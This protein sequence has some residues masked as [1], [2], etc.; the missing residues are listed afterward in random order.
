MKIFIGGLLVG[1]LITW[2]SNILFISWYL[3]ERDEVITDLM[4]ENKSLRNIIESLRKYIE[5]TLRQCHEEKEGK[6]K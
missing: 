6:E 2:G 5:E 3:K 1:M 4:A